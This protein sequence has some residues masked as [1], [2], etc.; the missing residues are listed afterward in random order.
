MGKTC[1]VVG[2][3]EALRAARSPGFA[4]LKHAWKRS[5]LA[6]ALRGASRATRMAFVA[7]LAARGYV[8]DAQA[9]LRTLVTARPPA[10]GRS[11]EPVAW[12]ITAALL[13]GQHW[14]AGALYHEHCA[15]R[16]EATTL[17]LRQY[18]RECRRVP[19]SHAAHADGLCEQLDVLLTAA[20]YVVAT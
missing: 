14:L 9:V 3:R 7:L 12:A 2:A 10:G 1:A 19:A 17:A 15:V 13:G 11:L 20:A 18:Q 8:A 6:E 16:G 4:E 5:A